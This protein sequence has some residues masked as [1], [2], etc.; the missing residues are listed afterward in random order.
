MPGVHVFVFQVKWLLIPALCLTGCI[1]ALCCPN[2]NEDQEIENWKTNCIANV[3]NVVCLMSFN[4]FGKVVESQDLRQPFWCWWWWSSPWFA[5]TGCRCPSSG[6]L[7]HSSRWGCSRSRI[8]TTIHSNQT[9]G[10]FSQVESKSTLFTSWSSYQS[11]GPGLCPWQKKLLRW[12]EMWKHFKIP[13][14]MRDLEYRRA[15]TMREPIR[16]FPTVSS[17]LCAYHNDCI[18]RIY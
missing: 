12:M 7:R 6:Q 3:A 10:R 13:P 16:A 4:R 15:S 18:T 1:S 9:W 17:Y 5:P 8:W 14:K 11:I 2:E